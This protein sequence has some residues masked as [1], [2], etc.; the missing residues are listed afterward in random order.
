MFQ[1]GQHI[2]GFTR[3]NGNTFVAARNRNQAVTFS[4]FI[5]FEYI[6]SFVAP[7]QSLNVFIVGTDFL[8]HLTTANQIDN[9]HQ[10]QSATEGYRASENISFR[11]TLGGALII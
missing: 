11:L 4:I 6:G 1:L 3:P 10:T 2:P 5:N 7:I 8:N 9:V